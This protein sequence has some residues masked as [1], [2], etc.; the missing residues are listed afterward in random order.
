MAR[1]NQARRRRSPRQEQAPP[2]DD[3]ALKQELWLEIAQLT[4]ELGAERVEL[5][6]PKCAAAFEAKWKE[7]IGTFI[8]TTLA[9]LGKKYSEADEELGWPAGTLYAATLGKISV[10]R[11]HD[12]K[13]QFHHP[14]VKMAS[15]AAPT[16]AGYVAGFRFIQ[17]ACSKPRKYQPNEEL[18]ECMRT[19]R[20]CGECMEWLRA[21]RSRPPDTATLE[22]I[23]TSLL[24]CVHDLVPHPVIKTVPDLMAACDEWFV[25]YLVIH[26]ELPRARQQ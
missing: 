7:V 8:K 23:G 18:Y 13:T 14:R 19:L 10:E 17:E 21:W 22:R 26:F 4:N 1:N 3:N 15:R 5:I 25:I 11:F 2:T 9:R 16:R 24:S 6:L 12:F 20:T